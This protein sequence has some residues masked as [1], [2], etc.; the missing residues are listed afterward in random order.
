MNANMDMEKLL[1]LYEACK[2]RYNYTI[3]QIRKSKKEL[4]SGCVS[5]MKTVD[6]EEN[7]KIGV[8]LEKE[9]LKDL[10]FCARTESSEL[11]KLKY[12]IKAEQRRI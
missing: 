5:Y 2:N 6:D 1:K 3:T 8:K 10:K 4:S 12:M 9:K 7:R 11:K